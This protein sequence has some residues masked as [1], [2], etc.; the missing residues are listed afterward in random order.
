M[1]VGGWGDQEYGAWSPDGSSIAYADNSDGDY[2]IW[3]IPVGGGA[4]VK[5]TDNSSTD[6]M[7]D[8]GVAP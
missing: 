6:W 5:L 1:V 7:P 2:E 8:W 4:G 3:T